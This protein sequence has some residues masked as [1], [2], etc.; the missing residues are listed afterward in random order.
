MSLVVLNYLLKIKKYF[1]VLFNLGVQLRI[2][3]PQRLH[4]YLV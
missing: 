4:V 3:L 1:R 2:K